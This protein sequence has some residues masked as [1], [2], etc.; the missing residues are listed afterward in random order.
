MIIEMTRRAKPIPKGW[1]NKKIYKLQF[2]MIRLRKCHPFGVF[3]FIELASTKMPSL[4][5]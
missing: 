2:Q 3:E 4:R 1:H 5:D